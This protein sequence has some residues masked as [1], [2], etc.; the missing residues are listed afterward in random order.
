MTLGIGLPHLTAAE[1]AGVSDLLRYMD[2]VAE[3]SGIEVHGHMW[4]A[5]GQLFF[6][7]ATDDV[8][9]KTHH[10]ALEENP[11]EEE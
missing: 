4:G 5:N 8:T 10:V 7:F 11:D 9:G 6:T 2:Q 3:R 1:M